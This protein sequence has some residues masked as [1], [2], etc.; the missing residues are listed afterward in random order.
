MSVFLSSQQLISSNKPDL[1]PHNLRTTAILELITE[2]INSELE[3][4]NLQA[5][6]VMEFTRIFNLEASA[7]FL[8]DEDYSKSVL[9]LHT[10]D[11]PVRLQ[12][13]D[14]NLEHGLIGRC[15]QSRQAIC[16]NRVTSEDSALLPAPLQDIATKAILCVPIQVKNQTIGVLTLFSRTANDFSAHDR[17]LV[18]IAAQ[19]I[20]HRMYNDQLIQ[21]LKIANADLEFNR[22]QLINSR[23][24]L[25]ALFDSFPA[26][27][28]IIDLEYKLVAINMH[29]ANRRGEHPTV[30]V[31]Q[32]CYQALCGLE[33]PCS[34]CRVLETL[35]GG[36]STN[37]TRRLC[38]SPFDPQEW[39]IN[40]YPIHDKRDQ[41]IQ[42]I[43]LEQD[44]TEKRHLEATL[45]QSEKLAAVGQLAAGL[46]HEINNPL[47]AVIANAQ[48]LQRELPTN[49]EKQELVDL[50]VRAGDRAT[51]VVHNLLDLAR[52]EQD[53]FSPVNIND[54]IRKSL[55]LLHHE[56]V[57]RSIRLTL[58][59]DEN[60]PMVV[61][62][63]DQL[64]GVWINLLTNAIDAVERD[65]REIRIWTLQN[66]NE[67]QIGV[68]DNGQGIPLK[69]LSRIFEPFYTTKEPGRGTGLGLSVCHQ[70][71]K[72]HRGQILVKSQVNE[73][74][75]FTVILPVAN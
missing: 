56:I 19:A 3:C 29:R 43:L 65:P 70:V 55:T 40:T 25:R 28:Y 38:E 71:I 66:G 16:S 49:D 54:T 17:H 2:V 46:A 34:D 30:L 27:L 21:E 24:I 5:V 33:E 58:D 60:I 63:Q 72:H 53:D 12:K 69:T 20:A 14:T 18:G 47:T 57:A 6:L 59:F 42:A 61:A 45:A 13:L 37:R 32:R 1:K 68:A 64:Q 26:S 15:L 35:A 10:L 22:W 75:Q 44:V 41:V 48:I 11:Q 9:Y 36:V 31:G 4:S 74:T 52:K 73:G 62:N 51:Q 67:V 50:I 23:N 8:L 39:E 7:L